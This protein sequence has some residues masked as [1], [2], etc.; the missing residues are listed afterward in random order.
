MSE[1]VKDPSAPEGWMVISYERGK[2]CCPTA[3]DTANLNA[4]TLD[5]DR[6]E[7]TG[8]GLSDLDLDMAIWPNTI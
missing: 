3:P 5:E 4:D 8:E 7:G 1:Y 2:M 6:D